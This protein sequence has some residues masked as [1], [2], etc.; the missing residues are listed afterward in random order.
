MRMLLL[1]AAAAAALFAAPLTLQAQTRE[2]TGRVT[3][4]DTQEPL[5]NVEIVVIGQAARLGTYTN[6]QGRYRLA[7]VGDAT[8]RLRRLGYQA[9]TVQA[10]AAQATIDIQLDR[11]VLELGSV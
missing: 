9:R 11:D 8:L 10:T 1:H 7:V 2:I 5:G 6:D 3:S 4:R